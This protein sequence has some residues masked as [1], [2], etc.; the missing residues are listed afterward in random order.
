MGGAKSKIV[1]DE[2]SPESQQLSNI[3]PTPVI[4]ACKFIYVFF[5]TND[6][7]YLGMGNNTELFYVII[8][9]NEPQTIG[10]VQDIITKTSIF[11]GF[12]VVPNS[13]SNFRTKSACVF[14]VTIKPQRSNALLDMIAS[15]VATISEDNRKLSLRINNAQFVMPL[16]PLNTATSSSRILEVRIMSRVPSNLN[17]DTMARKTFTIDET[18]GVIIAGWRRAN[19]SSAGK[20]TALLT[21]SFGALASGYMYMGGSEGISSATLGLVSDPLQLFDQYAGACRRGY[22]SVRRAWMN[23]SGTKTDQRKR[24]LDAVRNMIDRTEALTVKI[25][26]RLL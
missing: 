21:S 24:L 18:T 16:W 22:H 3:Q 8:R 20:A 11:S 9:T 26:N 13:E 25:S 2:E 5:Q 14:Q 17:Y 1:L 15:F 6:G 23:R 10:T 19:E 4:P 12:V 7:K